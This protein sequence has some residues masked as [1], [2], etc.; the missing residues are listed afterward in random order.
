MPTLTT[1]KPAQADPAA[2][3][4]K[5]PAAFSPTALR[6]FA[7]CRRQYAFA[8]LEKP[9]VDEPASPHLVLG[10]AVHQALAFIFRLP[11]G[12]RADAEANVAVAHRALRHYWVRQEGRDE[13]FLSP[14]DEATWGQSGLEF[15]TGYCQDWA[16]ELATLEPLAVEDWVRAQLPGGPAIVGKVDRVDLIDGAN[17]GAGIRVVDY[18][19]GRCRIKSGDELAGDVG[20]Q[21]YAVAASYTY[22]RVVREVRFHWLKEGGEVTW[23]LGEGDLAQAESVIARR[24]GELQAAS[25]FPAEPSAICRYCSYRR[26]CPEGMGQTSLEQLQEVEIGF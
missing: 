17:P 18:K 23:Q 24:T 10:N 12:Q 15:L 7:E 3:S 4:A 5:H 9:E 14:A 2:R 19:T 22:K 21:L 13:A 25:D 20:A 16:E 8:Y 26:L 1:T 6:T 11:L